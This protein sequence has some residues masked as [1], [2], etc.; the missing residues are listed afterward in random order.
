MD[1]RFALLG[2]GRT[3]SALSVS[4]LLCWQGRNVYLKLNYYCWVGITVVPWLL[5]RGKTVR[6]IPQGIVLGLFC[7]YLSALRAPLINTAVLRDKFLAE[8][9][10]VLSHRYS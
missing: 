5:A 4:S 10:A 8:Y 6:I 7:N 9:Q 2:G 1:M 3:G